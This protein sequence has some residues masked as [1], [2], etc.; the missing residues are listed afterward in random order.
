MLFSFWGTKNEISDSPFDSEMVNLS[1]T[2]YKI[3]IYLDYPF[4]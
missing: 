1:R 4:E 2:Q 3:G